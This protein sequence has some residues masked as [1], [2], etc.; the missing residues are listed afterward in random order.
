[1]RDIESGWLAK[2]T[3]ADIPTVSSPSLRERLIQ[4]ADTIIVVWNK[5]NLLPA[6]VNDPQFQEM[7]VLLVD[8]IVKDLGGRASIYQKA[9]IIL[10]PHWERTLTVAAVVKKLGINKIL[11]KSIISKSGSGTFGGGGGSGGGGGG[12]NVY[13]FPSVPTHVPVPGEGIEYNLPLAPTN[14]VVS[15]AVPE[16]EKIAVAI[17][18][19]LKGGRRRRK[20]YTKRRRSKR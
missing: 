15:N 16:P 4:I 18:S 6:D 12:G 2:G 11:A 9:N 8:Q 7:R 17:E 3:S 13:D 5:S 14:V 20:R 10:S 19:G 1:M